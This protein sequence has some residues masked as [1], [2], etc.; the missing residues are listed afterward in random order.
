MLGGIP[1]G[2]SDSMLS[3]VEAYDSKTN[4][5]RSYPPMQQ[6]RARFAVCVLL[7]GAIACVGGLSAPCHSSA[8]VEL[9]D[10]DSEIWSSLPDMHHARHGHGAITVTGASQSRHADYKSFDESEY[11]VRHA[12]INAPRKPKF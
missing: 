6:A 5:W 10:L 7:S 1:G 11:G 12:P 2:A 4:T 8:T 9:L 3:N